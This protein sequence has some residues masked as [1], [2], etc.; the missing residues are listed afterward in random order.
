MVDEEKEMA[1]FSKRFNKFMNMNK[2]EIGRSQRR[3]MDKG[4]MKVMVA[5]WSDSE[6]Y[7]N[8]ESIDDEFSNLCSMAFEEQKV[9]SNF[10][11][12]IPYTFNEL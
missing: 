10:C 3:D 11:D 8:A 2:N 12:S 9:S 4:K 7:D 1:M 6:Y 5:T